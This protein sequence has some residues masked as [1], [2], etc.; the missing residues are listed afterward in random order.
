MYVGANVDSS[1]DEKRKEL[2]ATRYG[3]TA[4]HSPR[5]RLVTDHK[6]KGD[7]KSEL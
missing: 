1:N 5:Q 4:E 3:A 6:M 7:R 2:Q